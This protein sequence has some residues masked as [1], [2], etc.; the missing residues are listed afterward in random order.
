MPRL[1]TSLWI[2]PWDLLDEG[3]VN[4]LRQARDLAG[5]DAVNLAVTYHAGLFLLP[6]NPR[7]RLYAAEDGVVYFRADPKWFGGGPQPT[8]SNLTDSVD[9]LAETLA[10]AATV[11]LGVRAWMVCCHN[12]R[13]AQAQ[14]NL[15]VQNALG[16]RLPFGLC[17]LQPGVQQYLAGLID[18]LSVYPQLEAIELEALY[19]QPAE[20]SWHHAKFGMPLDA[21]A[22]FLFG[23]CC[24][25]ACAAA[26]GVDRARLVP[27]IQDRLLAALNGESLGPASRETLA[28]ISGE[29]AA[30]LEA[31]VDGLTDLL[32]RLVGRA[33]VPVRA[34]VGS[35]LV[36]QPWTRGID[37]AAWAHLAP[38]VTVNAYHGPGPRPKSSECLG[39]SVAAFLGQLSQKF[40][41]LRPVPK[42]GLSAE[43]LADDVRRTLSRFR[44]A[45][46]QAHLVVGLNATYPT[47]LDE[48]GL[49]AQTDAALEHGPVELS[50]YHYG[51]LGLDRLAWVGRAAAAARSASHEPVFSD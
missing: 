26:A 10:A 22:W 48:A 9:P 24:C 44:A 31:R 51:L 46:P 1:R 27:P 18:A 3:P 41:R 36:E 50:Y 28:S 15:A 39:V 7:R 2:Y 11:D 25:D 14:P 23:L 19:W 5:A 32:A 20:H 13:L 49:R 6:H 35:G 45:A 16:D 4:A 38:S 17:P 12:S 47:T 8:L 30:L 43:L 21:Q 42:S 40:G 37:L 29:M 33:N 34:L